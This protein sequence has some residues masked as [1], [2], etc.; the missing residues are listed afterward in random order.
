MVACGEHLVAVKPFASRFEWEIHI[1][2]LQHRADFLRSSREELD[3][4]AHGLR[5][6]MARLDEVEGGVQCNF[7]LNSVPH[8]EKFDNC[9]ESYH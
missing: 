5:R 9:Q 7:F 4:F 1:L 2:P 3:D 6:T 8:G